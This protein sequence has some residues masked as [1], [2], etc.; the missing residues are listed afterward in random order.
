MAYRLFSGGYVGKDTLAK[1][2]NDFDQIVRVKNK[3]ACFLEYG[4]A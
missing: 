3:E 2:L 1:E 4:N